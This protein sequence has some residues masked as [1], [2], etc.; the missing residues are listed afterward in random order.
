MDRLHAIEVFLEIA[1]RGS[2][3][4]AAD[5]LSLS[6]PSV[7]RTLAALERHL[8]VRLFNRN[9][10]RLAITEEGRV[11]R[12]HSLAIRAAVAESEQA[13]SRAQAEPTGSITVTASVKFG[14]L[15]VAP[16]VASY[17]QRYP[18]V[19]LQLL[20]LDRVVNLVEEGIDL[21]VRIASLPD[22]SLVARHVADVHQVIAASPA[23]IESW[24]QP[25]QPQDLASLPCIR[26]DGFG[27][28]RLWEF[29][30]AG[31]R[32]RIKIDGRMGCN[33]VGANLTAC[34]AGQGFGRFL[35]YQVL[36]AIERGELVPVLQAYAPKARPL[37]LVYPRNRHGSARLS[38]LAEHLSE[39]LRERLRPHTLNECSPA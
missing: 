39:G 22:S 23:L 16:L 6:L 36:G 31:R 21:A 12:E 19:E 10:R 11:Y 33:T 30:S 2:L 37:S 18:S 15:H 35:H 5:A 34:M 24:G 4:R 3:T 20:L 27:D 28:A 9:T 26:F 13:M 1:E 38:T 14:E 8:G 17:L 7:V 25:Q 29:S 32:E